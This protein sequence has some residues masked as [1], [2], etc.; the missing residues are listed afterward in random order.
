LV[1]EAEA[2]GLGPL[3]STSLNRSGEPSVLDAREAEQICKDSGGELF[4]LGL[5]GLAAGPGQDPADLAL[6]QASTVV[7]LCG[8]EMEILRQGA[9]GQEALVSLLE[10]CK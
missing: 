4:L 6:N 3:T 1:F 5:E 9:I 8:E 7:D 10:S 2:S